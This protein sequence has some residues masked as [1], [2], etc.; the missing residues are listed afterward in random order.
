[1]EYKFNISEFYNYNNMFGTI[2]QTNTD[3][4]IWINSNKQ[5]IIRF[6][7]TG[8]V[9]LR[10]L[11]L[12]KTYTIIHDNTGNYLENYINDSFTQSNRANTS[13]NSKLGFGHRNGAQYLK[14]KIYYLKFWSNEQLVRNLIPCYN[15]TTNKAGLCDI[16][17]NNTF[18]DNVGSGSFSYNGYNYIT[19]STMVDQS[20]NHTLYAI[21]E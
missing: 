8:R 12:N 17:N 1:M 9:V 11:E 19:S 21:W 4:E 14:G 16:A 2:D 13:L 15:T 7:N 3:N 6:P 10:D 5:Y 18:Y 20:E